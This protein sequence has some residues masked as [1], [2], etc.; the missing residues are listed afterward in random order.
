[1]NTKNVPELDEILDQIWET[2]APTED[3]TLTQ[4]LVLLYNRCK[5]L[6][7]LE[8]AEEAYHAQQDVLDE[9]EAD[10]EAAALKE[11]SKGKD[12]QCRSTTGSHSKPE[13]NTAC[14][15]CKCYPPV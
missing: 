11:A 14:E 12:C 9:I 7:C 13:A 2:F 15:I 8:K 10:E 1:M 3:T 4:A 6:D 5:E